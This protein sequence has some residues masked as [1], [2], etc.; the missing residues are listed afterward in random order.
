MAKLLTSLLRH[1]GLVAG[2]GLMAFST[3]LAL[4]HGSA[5]EGLT[6]AD[7][8]P[9]TVTQMAAELDMDPSAAGTWLV[10]FVEPEQGEG[11]SEEEIARLVAELQAQGGPGSISAAGFYSEGEH[12]FRLHGS[13]T[14]ATDLLEHPLVEGVE[15]EMFYSLPSQGI[16][17]TQ[18][19]PSGDQAE[20]AKGP[21][22][23]PD[24]PMFPLQWHMEQIRAPRPGRRPRARAW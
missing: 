22:L 20:I 3:V 8:T 17:V 13:L 6:A 11:G 23:E 16:S 4:D 1:R 12:L 21:R 14:S 5:D 15:P 2:A 10:D 24:D 18:G 9:E 19:P 7:I